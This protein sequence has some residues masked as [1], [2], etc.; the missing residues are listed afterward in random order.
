[1]YT[2]ISGIRDL[3]IKKI[4]I[5][6]LPLRQKGGFTTVVC[7][8]NTKPPVDNVETL[9]YVL[10]EGKRPGFMCFRPLR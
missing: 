5:P 3:R 2:S 6:A 7:M 9:R 1:M 4:F 10:E 8:A